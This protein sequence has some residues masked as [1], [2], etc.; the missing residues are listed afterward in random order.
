MPGRLHSLTADIVP[1]FGASDEPRAS[2]DR[3]PPL[4][5]RPDPFLGAGAQ[6]PGAPQSVSK[7]A[8]LALGAALA[9][10][11]CAWGIGGLLAIGLGIAARN[12]TRK[13]P[14]ARGSGM[15]LAAIVLGAINV[16][17]TAAAVAVLLL[18]WGQARLRP[19]EEAP[20]FAS[21]HEPRPQ[22]APPSAV[23]KPVRTSHVGSVQIIDLDVGLPSLATELERQWLAAD[24]QGQR[25]L[26]W[27]VGPACEPCEAVGRAL[28]DPR[29][30]TALSGARILRL[31]AAR[32]QHELSRLR[33]PTQA[34]PGFAL[35]GKSGYPIDYIHGGEWDEDIAPNIAPVLGKFVR[36]EYE[37]RR[38]PWRGGVRDD[39]TAL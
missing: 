13:L 35:I 33:L 10:F 39:E 6:S 20:R 32:F 17:V 28:P 1:N 5:P 24:A 4:A 36:G 7:L 23:T 29:M 2:N 11:A 30:Q 3:E 22:L 31:D 18:W 12:E 27:T 34:L 21:Q 25:L 26:L 37:G 19:V 16:L 8:P 9:S 38:Y 14:D 15:A